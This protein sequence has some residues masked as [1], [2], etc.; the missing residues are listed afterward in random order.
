MNRLLII[1]VSLLGF[2]SFA[3]GQERSI[4][5]RQSSWL[6]YGSGGN[7]PNVKIQLLNEDSALIDSTEVMMLDMGSTYPSALFAF[8][9][10]AKSKTYII[11]VSQ[12]NYEKTFFKYRL[13]NVG[14][15]TDIDLPSS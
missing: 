3:E 11:C 4:L 2:L 8:R 6:I 13:K 1:I 5:L 12:P 14:R 7:I 10:P 15:N 9:V